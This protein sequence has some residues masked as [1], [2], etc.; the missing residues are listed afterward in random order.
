M[1]QAAGDACAWSGALQAA[2]SGLEPGTAHTHE[3]TLT[4]VRRGTFHLRLAYDCA[5]QDLPEAGASADGAEDVCAA[6]PQPTVWGPQ[7]YTISVH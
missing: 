6:L 7:R 4:F 3:V 5:P 2:M 1:L